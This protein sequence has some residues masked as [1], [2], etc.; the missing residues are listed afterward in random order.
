[1]KAPP[2]LEIYRAHAPHMPSTCTFYIYIIMQL[3]NMLPTTFTY[4]YIRVRP[5]VHINRKHMGIMH[6]EHSRWAQLRWPTKIDTI[7]DICRPCHL[8]LIILEPY[9]RNIRQICYAYTCSGAQISRSGDF[10]VYNDNGTTDFSIPCTCAR[11]QS[12]ILGAMTYTI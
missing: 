2:E 7:F 5:V 9:F 3:E 1:M 4:M 12:I 8:I 6:S 10:C 11:G